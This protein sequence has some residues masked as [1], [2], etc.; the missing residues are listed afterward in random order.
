VVI[1]PR[2]P[3]AVRFRPPDDEGLYRI[4]RLQDR[5]YRVLDT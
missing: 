2:C 4:S 5:A 3:R 1:D